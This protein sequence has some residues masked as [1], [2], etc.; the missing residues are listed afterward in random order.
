MATGSE[1]KTVR[2]W[3]FGG[4]EAKAKATLKGDS[5]PVYSLA[6]T[7]DGKLAIAGAN[8]LIRIWDPA[9]G[10]PVRRLDGH[11]GAVSCI[12]I[13]PDG[14]IAVTASA[15]KTARGWDARAGKDIRRPVGHEVAPSGAAVSPDGT[16]GL[17][18]GGAYLLDEKNRLVVK[19]G[20]Y[21]FTDCEVRF[22]HIE[23]GQILHRFTNFTK[24]VSCVAFAPDGK[25]GAAGGMDGTIRLLDLGAKPAET[26]VL[27]DKPGHVSW[28]AY[29]PD[30]KTLA[31]LGPSASV[32]LWDVAT[33]KKSREWVIQ[34]NVR[35]LVYS[36]DGRYLIVSVDTA[37]AYVLRLEGLP[38]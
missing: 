25:T 12:Q 5:F 23:T 37:V 19:D 29:S 10:K 27:Q 6:Y 26:K 2:L 28:L 3:E 8:A 17:A 34:E 18:A 16:R 15:D 24:P 36:P 20:A 38:E 7:G 35:K 21:V 22:W 31:A 33:G 14:R 30:G 9:T 32:T 1:D 13:T 4:N 11:T